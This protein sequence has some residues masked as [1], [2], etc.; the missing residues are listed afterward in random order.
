MKKYRIYIDETGNS[1]LKSSD[2]PNHRF[3]SLTGVIIDLEYVAQTIRPEI[4]KLKLDYF[5][6]HPDDPVVLHRKEI[7]SAQSP[8]H[9]LKNSD[10][11]KKFDAE[12]LNLLLRW[13]YSVIT[14]CIDKQKHRQSYLTS[15]H[16]YHYCLEILLERFIFFLDRVNSVGD[17]MAESRGGKED[18]ILK[19]VFN[20][21]YRNGSGYITSDRFEKRLTSCQ[22]KV[23]NKSNNVSGLQIADLL[24]H[25]S[26]NE[27]L[28]E[29]GL[30]QKE[31]PTFGAEI[32]K[33]LHQKYYRDGDTLYGKKML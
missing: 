15:R 1:D 22:L 29:H 23:K 2:N 26:R 9:S 27:L 12:L 16:P 32:I 8:F 4:E 30:F 24:A 19:K 11:R 18:K 31:L 21:L 3:L 14:I 7:L 13:D 33:I 10:I 6:S 5:A 20:R 17:V 25:P 28:K